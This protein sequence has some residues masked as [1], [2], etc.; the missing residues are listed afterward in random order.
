M[1]IKHKNRISGGFT[2][3][4]M[5]VTIVVTGVTAAGLLWTYQ[6][7]VMNPL[8]P[9]DSIRGAFLARERLEQVAFDLSQSFDT[10]VTANYPEET[11]INE[12]G[13]KLYNRRVTITADHVTECASSATGEC[14]FIE[15]EVTVAA[16][17]SVVGYI[18]YA[19]ERE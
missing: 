19:A 16:S 3:I 6:Q 13:F 18:S 5:I 1:H 17:G 2:L 11:P 7:T 4:E 9:L 14:K 8:I 15:V 12:V 10:V